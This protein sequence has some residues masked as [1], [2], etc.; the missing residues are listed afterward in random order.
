MNK[1]YVWFQWG[2]EEEG[3]EKV[4]YFEAQNEIEAIEKGIK[5]YRIEN[6]DISVKLLKTCLHAKKIENTMKEIEK[7][8]I[9]NPLEFKKVYLANKLNETKEKAKYEY[10]C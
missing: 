4:G 10:G 7:I 1:Y 8:E 6:S 5:E 2:T 9:L 3:M